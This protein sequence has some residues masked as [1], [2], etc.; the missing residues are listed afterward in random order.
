MTKNIDLRK[1]PT[2]EEEM[3][4]YAE[5]LAAELSK[6]VAEHGISSLIQVLAKTTA[7][8]A[9]TAKTHTSQIVT[10]GDTSSRSSDLISRV[11]DV[12][13]VQGSALSKRL[14]DLEDLDN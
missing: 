9:F 2:T 8:L 14:E 12:Q 13:N 5:L 10:L 11:L 6:E 7:L 3:N 4:A 1:A